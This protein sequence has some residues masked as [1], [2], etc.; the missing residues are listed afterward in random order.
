MLLLTWYLDVLNENIKR[1][2]EIDVVN[3]DYNA[4]LKLDKVEQSL[5]DINKRGLEKPSADEA[6]AM[7]KE[8]I[9]VNYKS[10]K[11]CIEKH[12]I[13]L[14]AINKGNKTT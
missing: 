14:K 13:M 10:L 12:E 2:T 5:Q 4:L 6:Y 3:A 9:T 11:E 7:D 8:F 1:N